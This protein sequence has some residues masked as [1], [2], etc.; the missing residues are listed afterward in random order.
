[1]NE[2]RTFVLDSDP[3]GNWSVLCVCKLFY[4]MLC[5]LMSS[6]TCHS[7]PFIIHT[8]VVPIKKSPSEGSAV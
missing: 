3:W 8:L 7:P 6:E 5:H 4:V 2:A 1:M